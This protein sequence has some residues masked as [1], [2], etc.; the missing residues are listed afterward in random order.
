[1]NK[2]IT[3]TAA[4]LCF[5]FVNGVRAEEEGTPM[6]ALQ[7]KTPSGQYVDPAS[8]FRFHGY[9]S[10][11]YTEAEE[12]LGTEPGS[13][14]QILVSG[15]SPR[16]GKNEGGFKNDAALFV[17]GE[18]FE[19]V[20]GVIEIH[21]VGDAADPV[22]TE[23]KMTWDLV[24]SE[25]GDFTFRLV[26]GR[27]WWPFGIHNGEWFSAV[28]RFSL[29]SPAA[30][31]VLSAHYNEVGVMGEGEL[32]LHSN[33]GLNYVVSVGN[34]VPGFG[35]M[36]N[37]RGTQFDTNGNRALT[38]RVGLVL[39]SALD[40]ELGFSASGGK[41]RSAEDGNFGENDPQRYEADF[42]AFGPDLT[43]GWKGLGLR[44][45]L[46]TSSEDLSGASVDDLARDGVTLEPS[47][48]F[49]RDATRFK[50]I[51]LVGRYGLADEETLSGDTFKRTQL[52]IGL[53][54]HITKAF[55]ARAGFVSQGEDEELSDV[56]NNAFSISLTS[57]F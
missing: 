51:T 41:L 6:E 13:T 44:S 7:R 42:T 46:Y 34:G 36:G 5:V 20:G 23:A 16:T 2:A 40:A 8:F 38:G 30:A 57:E 15:P 9:I 35:L 11:S 33:L 52:G 39:L 21:F 12:A 48:T 56:D 25:G 31:E 17:G 55:I 27:Y 18:P 47:Y 50:E 49:K 54:V 37:V 26:G 53:N 10:L 19:G 28:N 4:I 32:R 3:L 43:L 22:I 14:P 24:G 1:M 45:Y 29:L